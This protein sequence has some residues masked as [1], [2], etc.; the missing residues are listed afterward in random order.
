MLLPSGGVVHY[1]TFAEGND[2]DLRARSELADAVASSGHKMGKIVGVR[3]VREVAPMNWQ[4]AVDA[5]I[6]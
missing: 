3:K 5:E 2:S 6:T 1:Y 4:I